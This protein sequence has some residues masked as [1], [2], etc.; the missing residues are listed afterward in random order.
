[1]INT[2]HTVK[3]IINAE[4]IRIDT[5]K[6]VDRAKYSSTKVENSINEL[7]KSPLYSG[8]PMEK[9]IFIGNV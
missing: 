4:S 1:M 6:P 3:D 7:K 8:G 9:L 5:L 2:I